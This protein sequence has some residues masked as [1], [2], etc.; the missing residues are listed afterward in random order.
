MQAA[1]ADRL[2]A[3]L[4][5]ALTSPGRLVPPAA[6]LDAG[7]IARLGTGPVGQRALDRAL[8]GALGLDR[9]VLPADFRERLATAPGLRQACR[10]ALA[11]EAAVLAL[12]RQFVG[13]INQVRVRA[14]LL[15]ADR[16]ALESLLGAEVMQAILRPAPALAP[17][18][19]LADPAL[20]VLRAAEGQPAPALRDQPLFRQGV[21]LAGALIAAEEP[22]LARLWQAR[23]LAEPPALPPA[24]PNAAQAEAAWRVLAPR[25]SES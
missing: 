20:P 14:A 6:H 18:A 15:K 11:P 3:G 17:L 16:R 8:A 19:G 25:T 2:A 13:A 7:L 9:A 21:A 10:L 1:G 22:L 24:T 12:L 4:A 5:T 23:G